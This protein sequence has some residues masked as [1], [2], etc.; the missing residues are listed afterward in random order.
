MSWLLLLPLLLPGTFFPDFEGAGSVCFSKLCTAAVDF[1]MFASTFIPRT[2]L[3]ARIEETD[4]W[5]C[6]IED[7]IFWR[8]ADI[9]VLL[10]AVRA[11]HSR[12]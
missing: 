5:V 10:A 12:E 4:F 7:S 3:R 9:A 6:L 8:R 11:A 2:R 1:E